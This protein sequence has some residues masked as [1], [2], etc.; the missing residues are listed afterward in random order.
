VDAR[1][2]LRAALAVVVV[3]MLLAAC[4]VE[5]QDQAQ[6]LDPESVPFDLLDPEAPGVS[7][8]PMGNF[9][10][11]FLVE[12]GELIDATRAVRARPTVARALKV[13]ERGPTSDEFAA[14]ITTAIPPGSEIRRVTV[15]NHTA[16]VDVSERFEENVRGQE[17]LA[18]AQVVYTAT[19]LEGVNRVRFRL[20]GEPTVVPRGNGTQTSRPVDRNDYPQP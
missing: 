10:V 4:G 14:G 11:I 5:A 19:G 17:A 8:P 16:I 6:E 12:G 18:L 3:A 7:V 20:E 9:F 13:L 1:L 15:R 2:I